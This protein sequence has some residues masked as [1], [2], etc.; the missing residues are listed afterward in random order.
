MAL[1]GN[2]Y[3]RLTQYGSKPGPDGTTQIDPSKLEPYAAES[4]TISD[5]GKTY[6]FKLRAGAK[7]PSGKPVDAEAV[8]YSFDRALKMNGCGGYFLHDGLLD[9]PLISSVDAKDATTVVFNLSQADPNALTTKRPARRSSRRLPRRPPHPSRA[10]STPSRRG[11]PPTACN[12][13]SSSCT[14]R[15]SAS[16]RCSSAAGP[17]SACS[18]RRASATCGG[19]DP[20]AVRADLRDGDLTE[21]AARRDHP[22]AFGDPGAAA[23][24]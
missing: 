17:S 20:A 22:H 15:P 7:F 19:G 2:L 21:S 18:R 12:R 3:S 1:I 10:S 6:T 11:C 4:W 23:A 16:T 24:T 8:T 9:P 5:D 13:R 14:G